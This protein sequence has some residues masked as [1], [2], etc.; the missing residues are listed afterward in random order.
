MSSVVVITRSID[1]IKPHPNA[2]KL[3]L[4]VVGGWQTVVQKG[5][6][7][8]GQSVTYVP[9]D[10]LVPP[11][12]SDRW[13]V[14]K[15]LSNGRVRAVRLR[16]EPSYGFV[17]PPEGEPGKNVAE[18]LGIKKW[19][20]PIKFSVGDCE[21]AHSLFCE[22]T[23]VENLRHY[24]DV[25]TPGEPVIYSEKIHGTN[26]RIA[27]IKTPDGDIRIAGSRTMQRKQAE[28]SVYW[29]PWADPAVE[30]AMVRLAASAKLMVIM[31]GEVYG[32]V[33]SLRYGKPNGLAYAA[34]DVMVDGA[35]LSHDEFVAATDGVARVPVVERGLFSV[36]AAA[37]LSGGRS[38]IDGAEHIREGVVVRPERER[39]DPKIGRV[40]L[41]YVSDAYLCGDFDAPS[42]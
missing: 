6:Y 5:T 36:E 9:P 13:G 26:S 12:V 31:Y 23:D 38:L 7:Q 14:T 16:G 22:Y 41:K 20:P 1:E 3:E 32:K 11:E 27:I 29:F 2:D 40:I 15:Y 34:F 10:C 25:F 39:R 33:Q 42:E 28:N 17:V 18:S 4:A 8:P 37:R 35:F 30:A 24:T 21:P 19:Q